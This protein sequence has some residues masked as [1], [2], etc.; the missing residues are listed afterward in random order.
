M[1]VATN[2]CKTFRITNC[3]TQMVERVDNGS[4][5][6]G[7][8]FEERQPGR[9]ELRYPRKRHLGKKYRRRTPGDAPILKRSLRMIK[10]YLGKTMHEARRQNCP[11]ARQH[12]STP[13]I[14]LSL[15]LHED[16]LRHRA[17]A[18]RA[19]REAI[20]PLPQRQP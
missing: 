2:A 4:P 20:A 7:V 3:L 13:G 16:G 1:K 19:A 18:L 12:K 15:Q 10:P 6:S 17:I 9:K 11:L 8:P 14:T 5:T